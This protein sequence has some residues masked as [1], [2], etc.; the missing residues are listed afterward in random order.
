MCEA[1]PTKG[2]GELAKHLDDNLE[3]QLKNDLNHCLSP[4]YI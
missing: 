1:L 2:E 4:G 3:Q